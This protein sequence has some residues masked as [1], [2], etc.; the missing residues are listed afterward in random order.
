MP[1][2]VLAIGIG[3]F[4]AVGV[5]GLSVID[6]YLLV[7]SLMVMVFAAVSLGG[8]SL[9]KPGRLQIAWMVAALAVVGY[10]TVYTVQRVNFHAFTNELVFRGD[11]HRALQRTLAGREVAAG[12]RCGPVSTPN[13]KLIP[14]VRWVLDAREKDVVARSEQTPSK[15][16]ALLTTNRSSVLRQALVDPTDQTETILPPNGFLGPF[17]VSGFYSVYVGC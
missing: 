13:H 6:R 14:D 3:T 9:L 2:A 12:R 4:F 5:A 8:W 16:V 17:D 15:G 7:P 10:G 11:S 1:L